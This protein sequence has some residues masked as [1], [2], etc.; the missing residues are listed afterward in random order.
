M[1]KITEDPK[2]TVRKEIN[3]FS[4]AEIIDNHRKQVEEV[5]LKELIDNTPQADKIAKQ[6]LD[7]LIR[8]MKDDAKEVLLKVLGFN[9]HWGKWE[10]DHCNGRNGNSVIGAELSTTFNQLAKEFVTEYKDS[11]FALTET[12]YQQLTKSIHNDFIS[13]L[14]REA[15]KEAQNLAQK[16]AKE[17]ASK[18]FNESQTNSVLKASTP[19]I[20]LMSNNKDET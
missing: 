2:P 15:N 16:Y 7:E 14:R 17:L 6:V 3:Q 8:A 13:C 10:L 19:L 12:E 9:D 1:T 5:I 11:I 18:V 4:I 20:D